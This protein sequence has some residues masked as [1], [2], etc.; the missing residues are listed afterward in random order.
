MKIKLLLIYFKGFFINCNL[1]EGLKIKNSNQLIKPN[2]CPSTDWSNVNNKHVLIEIVNDW[3]GCFL[4]HVVII[5]LNHYDNNKKLNS[6]SEKNTC[7][8]LFDKFCLIFRWLM[9]A[10]DFLLL[11]SIRSNTIKTCYKNPNSVY[12]QTSTIFIINWV[13]KQ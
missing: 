1:L 12:L 11:S 7:R 9:I 6:P 8:H 2:W 5:I 3:L 4:D 13:S 10:T